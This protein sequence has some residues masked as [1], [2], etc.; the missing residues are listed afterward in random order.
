MIRRSPRGAKVDRDADRFF[1]WDDELGGN[2]NRDRNRD[3]N[4]NRNRNRNRDRWDGVDVDGRGGGVDGMALGSRLALA[5]GD[6]QE[7]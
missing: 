6:G 3:R 2:R 4:R 5:L 1:D 7:K